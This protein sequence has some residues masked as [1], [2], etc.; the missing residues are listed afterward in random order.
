MMFR[1]TNLRLE[2]A[3]WTSEPPLS[4]LLGDPI[5]QALMVA[6]GVECQHL[7]ALFENARSRQP[8]F[9]EDHP[10]YQ[11]FEGLC[12]LPRMSSKGTPGDRYSDEEADRRMNEVIGRALSPPPKRLPMFLRLLPR[13][14]RSTGSDQPAPKHADSAGAPPE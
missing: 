9:R 7:E 5:V 13:K 4:E 10:R 11:V 8:A 14:A 12:Y 1:E 6:D 3:E 2:P